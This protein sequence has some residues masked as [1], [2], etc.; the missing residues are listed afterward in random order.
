MLFY[1]VK[2][3][4]SIC[5]DFDTILGVGCSKQSVLYLIYEYYRLQRKLS[6]KYIFENDN[7][8]I[9]ILEI[10]E[11]DYKYFIKLYEQK[12]RLIIQ[13]LKKI[14]FE[15]KSQETFFWNAV[16]RCD[17][18]D[19]SIFNFEDYC[20]FKDICEKSRAILI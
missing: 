19:L 18:Q 7:N 5:K 13:N 6:R 15:P 4:N 14:N 11:E 9:Q 1:L 17:S 3:N 20:K 12:E 8:D 16:Y 2:Y 10:N